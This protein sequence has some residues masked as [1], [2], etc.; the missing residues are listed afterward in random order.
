VSERYKS[1]DDFWPFYLGEHAK[2]AT[3]TLH[4]IGTLGGLAV[5]IAALTSRHWMLIPAALVLSYGFAWV[6]HF[7][8]EKNR[9]ATF[10]YPLWSFIGDWKMLF[11]GLTGRLPG[12]LQRLGIDH[13]GGQTVQ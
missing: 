1:F 10:S 7:T 6:S 12:E 9:P 2:S 4:M 13:H 11:L 5:F 3:R 8:I